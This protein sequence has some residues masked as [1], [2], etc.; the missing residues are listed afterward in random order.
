[1]GI[2]VVTS[3]ALHCCDILD[4]RSGGPVV[5]VENIYL[6]IFTLFLCMGVHWYIKVWVYI[7][8]CVIIRECLYIE[9]WLQLYMYQ[10]VMGTIEV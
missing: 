1:M 10:H 5:W 7:K 3:D 6:I 8:V 9:F 4:W 2:K